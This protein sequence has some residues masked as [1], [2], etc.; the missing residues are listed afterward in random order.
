MFI[1]PVRM[2]H[3]QQP[4]RCCLPEVAAI[5]AKDKAACC[6]NS[7]RCTCAVYEVKERPVFCQ[8]VG[9]AMPALIGTNTVMK[10]PK[11]RP[12][13]DEVWNS[14][15]QQIVRKGDLCKEIRSPRQGLGQA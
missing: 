9:I 5:V 4:S 3:P 10:V 6:R 15:T 14:K 7:L 2:R 1:P 13:C 12:K 8:V 11:S